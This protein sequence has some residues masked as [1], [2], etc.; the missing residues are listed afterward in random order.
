MRYGTGN[1]GVGARRFAL[2][3]MAV[4]TLSV[5]CATRSDTTETTYGS[6]GGLTEPVVEYVGSM[7]LEPSNGLP[8]TTVTVSG[9][10]FTPGPTFDL[11]W[12]SAGGA[13]N[14][15][16]DA[17]EEYHGR[18]FTPTVVPLGSVTAGGDGTIASTLPAPQ[19]FGFSHHLRPG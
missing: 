9:Q 11:T 4:A 12:G 1:G 15:Q 7:A 3:V 19:G 13:W 16:G 5:A 14:I 6:G 10:G 2:A 18:V 17:N 8:G